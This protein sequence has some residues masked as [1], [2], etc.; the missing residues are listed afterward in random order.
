MRDKVRLGRLEAKPPG[1]ALAFVICIQGINRVSFVVQRTIA[2]LR[3]KKIFSGTVFKVTCPQSIK[4]LRVV[5]P[6]G[7]PGDLQI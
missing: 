6:F 1:L 7:E 4:A 2:R 3:L 5:E